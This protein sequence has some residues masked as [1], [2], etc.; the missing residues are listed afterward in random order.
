[1]GV[2]R[3]IAFTLLGRG[4]SM[5]SGLISIFFIVRYLSPTEQGF[6][7]TFISIV[8]MQ[9]MLEFGMSYVVLQFSS[10][11]MARLA[12]TSRGTLEGDRN[13]KSRLR[14]LCVIAFK[15]VGVAAILIAVVLLPAGWLFFSINHYDAN[16]SWHLPWILLMISSIFSIL[17]G[18]LFALFEGCGRMA[19]FARVRLYQAIVGNL[20]AWFT[21][22]F[23]G[24]LLAI[25]F[26]NMA[27][28]AVAMVALLQKRLFF[29]ELFMDNFPESSINWKTEI[30]PFQWKIALGGLGGYFIFKLFT[31][32]LFIYQGPV[33][34]GQ[35]GLSLSIAGSVLAIS[36]AWMSTKVP[37]FGTLI[38]TEKFHELDRLFFHTLKISFVLVVFLG[39]CVSLGNLVIHLYRLDVSTRI[40]SPQLFLFLM[41]TT[42]LNYVFNA[43]TTYLRSHKQEPFLM[44]SLLSGMLAAIASVT[45]AKYFG[46]SGIVG[47]YFA[48]GL[49]EVVWGTWIFQNK[50][51][52]WHKVSQY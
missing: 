16:V 51:I 41:A 10:H 2:D 18:P 8:G 29:K 39:V 27:M 50:R 33:E 4:W 20:L 34:A 9:V 26:M 45:L 47:A 42:V 1:M 38:A 17:M 5:I 14:S 11:E 40:L 25:P 15:W 32:V 48:V 44:L 7:Y 31:P 19:E 43:Q 22:V 6:Y 28:L 12:W 30:W 3:A 37:R 52:L 36:A 24:G 13:A 49:V 35:L 46:T 21:L 23:G